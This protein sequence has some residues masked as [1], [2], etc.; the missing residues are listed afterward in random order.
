MVKIF[1]LIFEHY[2]KAKMKFRILGQAFVDEIVLSQ[3]KNRTL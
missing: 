2:E 1:F 3:I